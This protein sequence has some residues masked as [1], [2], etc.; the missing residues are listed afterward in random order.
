MPPAGSD[1]GAR[2][3]QTLVRG[4]DIVDLVASQGPIGLRDIAQ[5]I[6]LTHST[7]HRLAAALLARDFVRLDNGQYQL[8]PRIRALAESARIQRPLT[9]LARPHLERLARE[10]LD[11]VNLGIRDGGAVRYMDQARGGRRIEVRSVIGETRPLAT[12]GLGRALMLDE[13]EETWRKIFDACPD[14][15]RGPLALSAWLARMRQFRAQ[16]AAFDLEENEHRV[17]CVAAPIRD[18]RGQIIGALSLSSLPQYLDEARMASLVTPITQTAN[19]IAAE[20][21]WT[22]EATPAPRP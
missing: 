21:G 10:Q 5:Q 8:G 14:T 1:S 19:A 3:A 20:L 16:G 18:A 11:A 17:C 22:P 4:L 13:P 2:G 9:A 15:P 7:A 12:T 6:G